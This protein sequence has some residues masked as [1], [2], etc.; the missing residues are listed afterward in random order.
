MRL[1]V[2]RLQEMTMMIMMLA[3]ILFFIGIVASFVSAHGI[4]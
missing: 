1:L 2:A 4:V 3:G